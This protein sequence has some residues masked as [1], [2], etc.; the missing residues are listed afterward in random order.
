MEKKTHKSTFDSKAFNLSMLKDIGVFLSTTPFQEKMI[1][2]EMI[3]SAKYYLQFV[4]KSDDL[5]LFKDRDILSGL[6][7]LNIKC[8]PVEI[9]IIVESRFQDWSNLLQL[10][11][12]FAS[13]KTISENQM[14][15]NM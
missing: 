14:T 1:M 3:K 7:M 5:E 11:K 2:L 15:E 10:L 12:K 8:I 9:I 6:E 4:R 13:V